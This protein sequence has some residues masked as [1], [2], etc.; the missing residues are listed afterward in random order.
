MQAELE[1]L[2]C[3][4]AVVENLLEALEAYVRTPRPSRMKRE[5]A[6]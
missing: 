3:R 4:S 1:H 5:R 2:Y 6:A